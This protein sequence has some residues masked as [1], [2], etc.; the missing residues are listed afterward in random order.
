MVLLQDGNE[1][2]SPKREQ[3]AAI[4][5]PNQCSKDT[6]EDT[7]RSRSSTQDSKSTDSTPKDAP[8]DVPSKP[9]DDEGTPPRP[10]PLS[11]VSLF[12]RRYSEP[13]D[14]IGA[15]AVGRDGPLS[16]QQGRGE[17]KEEEEGIIWNKSDHQLVTSSLPN[18]SVAIQIEVSWY[19][20]LHNVHSMCIIIRSSFVHG[21][22]H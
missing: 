20:D 4:D 19:F 16:E 15:G 22:P 1:G 13:V 8:R 7:L 10:L 5:I 3:S 17:G 9:S 6:V 11:E 21:Y 14:V 2:S 12:E 18:S